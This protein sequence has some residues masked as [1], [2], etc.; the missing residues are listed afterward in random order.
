[1]KQLLSAQKTGP[2]SWQVETDRGPMGM[3]PFTAIGEQQYSTY[4]IVK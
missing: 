3:L 4:V 2:E 1:V